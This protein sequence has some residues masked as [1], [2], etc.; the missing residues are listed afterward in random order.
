MTKR[1]AEPPQD[2]MKLGDC[3]TELGSRVDAFGALKAIPTLYE[4]ITY[5]SRLEARWAVFF[6]CLRIDARYEHE[7]YEFPNGIRYLPDFWLPDLDCFIEIKPNEPNETC[8]LLGITY[9][10]RSERLPCKRDWCEQCEYYAKHPDFDGAEIHAAECPQP[11]RCPCVGKGYRDDAPR[12]VE[13]YAR[14]RTER[15]GT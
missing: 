4:G 13:A 9:N 10:G 5:R 2:P 12:L 1:H 15:F 14:A 7:G 6:H 3:L 8:G 11:R